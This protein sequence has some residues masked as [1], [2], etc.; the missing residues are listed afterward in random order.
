AT[1]VLDSGLPRLSSTSVRFGRRT[2]IAFARCRCYQRRA[3]RSSL[4]GGSPARPRRAG[5]GEADEEMLDRSG[6]LWVFGYGSLMWR[7]GFPFL[8]QRPAILR[9]AHRSLCVYSHVHR[10][11]PERPGL[12][13]GLDQGGSCRGVAFRVAAAERE[14]VLTYLRARE[15]VTAVYREIIAALRLIDSSDGEV[16]VP[17]L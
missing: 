3:W 4:A 9:G 6:D 8:E 1:S 15:Q 13:L 12:V 14:N 10:G 17:G 11:T 5:S 7:P 2:G 16:I